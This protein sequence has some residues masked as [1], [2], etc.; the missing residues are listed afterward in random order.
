MDIQKSDRSSLIFLQFAIAITA[1][2]PVDCSPMNSFISILKQQVWL[3]DFFAFCA[4]MVLTL[5]FA[6]YDI[7]PFA[8]LA[9]MFLIML[10]EQCTPV[11]AWLR[12]FLFGLGYF[13]TGIYWVFISIH[14]YGDAPLAFAFIVTLGL[15]VILSFFPAFTGYLLNRY[16]NN[17]GVIKTLCAFPAIWIFLEWLRSFLFSGFPWLLVGYSQT[18]SPLKGFAPLLSVYGVSLAAL[19]SSGLCANAYFLYKK[20]QFKYSYLALFALAILWLSGALLSMKP[21]T[22]PHGQSLQV[23]LVQGNIDQEL[24]WAPDHVQSSLERYFNLTDPLWGKSNLI[25]WPETAIPVSLQEAQPLIDSLDE[26]A[27]NEKTTLVTGIPVENAQ[28]EG[29]YNTLIMLGADKGAYVKRRLVPF[30]EYTPYAKWMHPIFDSMRIPMSNMLPATKPQLP[31]IVN[32]IQILPFICY[33][34]AFPEQV[35][36]RDK[37]VGIILTANN[38]AWFGHSPAQAQHLQM[39]QMRTI[40]MQRP[41]LF[42]S[43]T[44]LTAVIAPDGRIESMAP[45]FQPYVLTVDVQPRY[46]RTPLQR[47]SIDPILFLSL[48]L[49]GVSI[50]YRQRKI[51]SFEL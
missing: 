15:I 6:P 2:H 39:A 43:N 18:N 16:F 11:R 33:E 26:K 51:K 3:S 36:S 44:G 10:W 37:N 5:S 25:V 34:I 22:K 45:P 21:W 48:V 8:I 9:L 7:F 40:E 13:G 41:G 19:L 1:V 38:D 32:G 46:G 42:V 20:Q 24:K 30:G 23:S 17:M 29:Y 31:F 14:T 12:G 35:L 47:Y 50:Y 49:L 28:G 27:Q 4:G